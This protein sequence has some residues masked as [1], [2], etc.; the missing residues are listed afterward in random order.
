[1]LGRM[2]GTDR[3]NGKALSGIA[4][5]R[6]SIVNILSTPIGSR[7]MRR[8]YGSNLFRLVDAPTNEQTRI[9]AIAAT[10]DALRR[11]EPRISVRSVTVTFSPGGLAIDITGEY[12]PT[13]EAVSLEGIVVA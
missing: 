2:R 3:T 7:V 13:G 11:W 4:H 5:M 9:D 1:M 10:A 12:R 8:S 6:Q